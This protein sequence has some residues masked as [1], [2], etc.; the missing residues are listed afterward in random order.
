MYFWVQPVTK[1]EIELCRFRVRVERLRL[2]VIRGDKEF[3]MRE[4]K[5]I[6]QLVRERMAA[7]KVEAKKATDGFHAETQR[8]VGNIGKINSLTKELKDSNKEVEDV[9]SGAGS[10]FPPQDEQS[11]GLLGS[12]SS[13]QAS[14]DRN[15]VSVNPDAK[16]VEGLD[17]NGVA[18][19]P[20]A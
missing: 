16:K 4:V 12:S 10:N 19:N 11:L 20:D 2:A 9:L 17:H 13:D 15:G 7:L 18:K 8:T 1:E 14:V 3:P 5:N 6:A